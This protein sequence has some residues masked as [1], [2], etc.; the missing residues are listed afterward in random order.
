MQFIRKPHGRQHTQQYRQQSVSNGAASVRGELPI[1][2]AILDQPV[3]VGNERRV[4]SVWRC[5][6][7]RSVAQS[8]RRAR[9]GRRRQQPFWQQASTNLV[10][11]VIL[12]HQTLY[13]HVTLFQV[14]EHVINPDKLR[15]KIAEWDSERRSF[16]ALSDD[17]SAQ[18]AADL[19]GKAGRLK[20]GYTLTEA[21]QDARVRMLTGRPGR[22]DHG[23][24]RKDVQPGAR[25]CVSAEGLRRAP[26]CPGDHP[27]V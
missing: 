17:F 8:R 15:T 2:P 25:L 3:E 9:L 27:A 13:D 18:M 16:L 10:K 22:P 11:F 5:L 24:R 4:R 7:A 23:R 14:Y 20:P 26:Q 6:P 19:C 12:L 21:G 1:T